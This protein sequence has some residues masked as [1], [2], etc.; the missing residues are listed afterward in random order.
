MLEAVS[1]GGGLMRGIVAFDLV[2]KTLSQRWITGR[3]FVV[4]LSGRRHAVGRKEVPLPRS[5]ASCRREDVRASI[6][7][8]CILV[9][10][11]ERVRIERSLGAA[12]GGL[13]GFRT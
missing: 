2:P 9:A 7:P 11:S 8:G 1:L 3:G 12:P 10:K 6:K 5:F 4:R 13:P